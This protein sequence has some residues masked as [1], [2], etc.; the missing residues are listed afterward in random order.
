MK[1]VPTNLSNLKSKVDKLDVDRLVPVLFYLSKLSDVVKNDVVKEDVY[2]S[3]IKNVEDKIPDVTNLAN[4]AFLNAKV[5]EIKGE[6]SNVDNLATTTA[7]SA[8][9]NK[10]P[11]VSNLIK[12]TDYNT[13]IN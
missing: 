1:N 4:N 6:I 10:I 9:E 12:K 11:T 5:N 7:L 8:V 13:Q 2:N 3:K